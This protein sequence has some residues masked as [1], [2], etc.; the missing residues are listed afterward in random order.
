MLKNYLLL[1]IRN[2]FKQKGLSLINIS[3]LS[4][5]LA[6]FILFLLYALNEFSY[7]HFHTKSDNIY[8]VYRWSAAMQGNDRASGDVYMPMPLGPAMKED[9]PDVKQFVRFREG[10]GDNFVRSGN[11]I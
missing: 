10:W 1:A 2:L 7:D 3:G 9:L 5:G 4:I 8:R 11:E 6:C